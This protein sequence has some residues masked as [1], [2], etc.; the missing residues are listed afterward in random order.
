[1]VKRKFIYVMG[2]LLHCGKN[3]LKSVSKFQ[4]AVT[5]V[6]ARKFF[7]KEVQRAILFYQAFKPPEHALGINMGKI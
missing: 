7:D 4:Q 6:H 2:S 1:M 3:W 5:N